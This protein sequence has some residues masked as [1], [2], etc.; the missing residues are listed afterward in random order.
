LLSGISTSMRNAARTTDYDRAVLLA[1]AKMDAL[2]ADTH[3]PREA[4][5]QGP[6]DP[7]LLGGAEGGW[8]GRLSLF[9]GPPAMGPNVP[10]LERV[11]LEIWWIAGDKRRNFTLEGFRRRIPRPDELVPGAGG[12]SQ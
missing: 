7:A 5:L 10:V 12:A 2:L 6:I 1:R 8:R 9:E 4:V 11:E 3:I